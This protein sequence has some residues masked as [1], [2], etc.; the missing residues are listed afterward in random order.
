MIIIRATVIFRNGNV[1][2]HYVDDILIIYKNNTIN[3]HEVL[4]TFNNMT[5][6]KKF[7]MEEKAE[8]KINLLDI[9]I[10]KDDKIISFNIYRKPTATDT[11]I[12]ND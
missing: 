8:N 9:A 4:T 12:P 10:S 5:L 7:T 6:T 1:Y 11:I 3:I 2:F